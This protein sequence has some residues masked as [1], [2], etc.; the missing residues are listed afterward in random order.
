M[1][2]YEY[3]CDKCGHRFERFQSMADQP[4]QSCPRCESPV[5]RL[6]SAGGG[7]IVKGSGMHQ[8]AAG[9]SL[10]NLGKTCCGRSKRCDDSPCGDHS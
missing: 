10:E 5:H 2:T 8:K 7:V 9:C 3:E 6:I 1:P 4:I